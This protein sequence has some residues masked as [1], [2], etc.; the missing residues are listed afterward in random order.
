MAG[1]LQA[2]ADAMVIDVKDDVATALRDLQAGEQITVRR[3]EQ[4]VRIQVCDPIQFG[5]KIAINE[6]ASGSHVRKYGEVIGQ[7][8]RAI[9]IGQHVHVHNVEGIRGRG[10]QHTGGISQ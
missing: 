6:I 7:S 3:G 8:T 5:H 10:D 2:G 4:I 1:E 9:T